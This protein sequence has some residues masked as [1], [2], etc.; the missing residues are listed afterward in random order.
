[1]DLRLRIYLDIIRVP[2][3]LTII[4]NALSVPVLVYE[5]LAFLNMFFTS[6]AKWSVM[7]FLAAWAGLLCV[8]KCK[9]ADLSF[10]GP[11]KTSIVAGG[12]LGL[13]GGII[14]GF[15]GALMTVDKG[16]TLVAMLEI[17]KNFVVPGTIISA[18]VACVSA[19]WYRWNTR[20]D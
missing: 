11:T 3:I 4:Y 13:L 9:E 17:I 5:R 19:S 2:L 15:L 14:G 18:V 1:M 16:V 10:I 6:Y 20:F 12:W 7:I 8:K